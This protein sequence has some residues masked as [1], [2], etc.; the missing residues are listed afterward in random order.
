M[1]SH[2][3]HVEQIVP[4]KRQWVGGMVGGGHSLRKGGADSERP[5]KCTALF[6]NALPCGTGLKI[7]TKMNR[8]VYVN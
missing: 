1:H 5:P 8:G 6:F 4:G 7:M 3:C 2:R